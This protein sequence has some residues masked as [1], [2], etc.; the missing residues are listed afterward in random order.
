MWI[1]SV[2]WPLFLLH[3]PEWLFFQ[4][5][6]S[7]LTLVA[8]IPD[9]MWYLST[10]IYQKGL[11]RHNSEKSK[12]FRRSKKLFSHKITWP[13]T[14][15]WNEYIHK[16]LNTPNGEKNGEKHFFYCFFSGYALMTLKSVRA[17]IL[18]ALL[19]RR[20]SIYRPFW[21]ADVTWENT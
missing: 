20:Y 3:Y 14:L 15:K 5:L 6:T 9:S 10:S 12:L 16:D 18:R 17:T 19:T 21:L 4:G 7:I 8:Y 11:W 13:S 2:D 1:I